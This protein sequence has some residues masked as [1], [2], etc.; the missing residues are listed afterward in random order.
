MKIMV[1][2]KLFSIVLNPKEAARDH[3][4]IDYISG[5]IFWTCKI[6]GWVHHQT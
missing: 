1:F 3:I 2:Y 4:M 6:L 5:G